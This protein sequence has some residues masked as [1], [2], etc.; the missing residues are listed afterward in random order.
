LA[1]D[2]FTL[3]G[4]SPGS[5]PGSSVEFPKF[6]L[7]KTPTFP[8]HLML[9]PV[10]TDKFPLIPPPS[11]FRNTSTS[12][13]KDNA[14]SISVRNSYSIANITPNK[15]S[16]SSKLTG[17]VMTTPSQ[18]QDSST[19]IRRM[20]SSTAVKSRLHSSCSSTATNTDTEV[21]DSSFSKACNSENPSHLAWD[22]TFETLK[23][24]ECSMK[25]ELTPLQKKVVE[26]YEDSPHDSND[27]QLSQCPVDKSCMSSMSLAWDNTGEVLAVTAA[28]PESLNSS[29]QS[30]DIDEIIGRV[31][32]NLSQPDCGNVQKDTSTITNCYQVTMIPFLKRSATS[33]DMD[34]LLDSQDDNSS[35]ESSFK[36]VEAKDNTIQQD[37]QKTSVNQLF[38]FNSQSPHSHASVFVF[39]S[40]MSSSNTVPCDRSPSTTLGS[41]HSSTLQ[42][43][44][45]NSYVS[46]DFL[47][48]YGSMDSFSTVFE[49]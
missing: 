2:I 49:M 12:P 30:M 44:S 13:Q 43:C 40:S 10:S 5:V 47:S 18:S 14:S 42:P 16:S 27:S 8:T 29:L 45:P 26:E 31:A 15:S 11:P 28:S 37:G 9:S 22:S 20:H 25:L 19:T 17:L 36:N 4:F 7:Q 6:P 46:E 35:C 39:P 1:K 32:P 23:T 34:A 48:T 24:L 38:P 21:L 41:H 3:P 33:I